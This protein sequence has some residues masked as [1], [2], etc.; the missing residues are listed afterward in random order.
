MTAH[1]LTQR[2]HV[3]RRAMHAQRSRVQRERS[4]L[5]DTLVC[6]FTTCIARLDTR[7][8]GEKGSSR[9]GRV[10]VCGLAQRASYAGTRS[11]ST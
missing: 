9:G 4:V 3:A 1:T 11:V 10:Y 7:R 8:C 2:W 5:S 6:A